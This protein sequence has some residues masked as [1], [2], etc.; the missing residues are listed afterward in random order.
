LAATLSESFGIEA[1]LIKGSGGVFDVAVDDAVIYS[2][3]ETGRF[4]AHD[5]IIKLIKR[6]TP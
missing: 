5:E 1:K 4:P 6:K 3:H 2:K